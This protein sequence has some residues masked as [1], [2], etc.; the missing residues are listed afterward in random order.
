MQVDRTMGVVP[1]HYQIADELR[2]QLGSGELQP[3]DE[4]PTV[5][6]LAERWSCSEGVA[7]SGL[8]VLRNE[9]RITAGRG[10]RATVRHAPQRTPLA[11]DDSWSRIQKDLVLRPQEERER[12]GAIELTA[13]VKIDDTSLAHQYSQI[14]AGPELAEEFSVPVGTEL[15]QR[16]YEMTDKKTGHRLSWSISYVP[17][18]LIESN[19]DLL[20]ESKEP[21]PGG[22]QH[23]LYTVGIEIDRIV[24]RVIAVQPTPGERQKWGMESGVPMLSVWSKSIDVHDRAV[25]LSHANYPADRT[26]IIFSAQLQRWGHSS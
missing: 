22:H 2:S 9:G 23:Q 3:G 21:W 15:L 1:V 12:K 10:R 24:R 17:L 26:E 19:P 16:N 25:E 5:A 13:G 6:E 7:R 11:L 8:A 18:E 20:D 4:L 14:L